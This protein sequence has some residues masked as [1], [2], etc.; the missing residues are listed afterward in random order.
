MSTK[1]N[2]TQHRPMNDRNNTSP[3]TVNEIPVGRTLSVR[4]TPS[5][6][7]DNCL[8]TNCVSMSIGTVENVIRQ[9]FNPCK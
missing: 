2:A 1:T 9:T 6:Y 3:T 7:R 8:I 5:I 4:F